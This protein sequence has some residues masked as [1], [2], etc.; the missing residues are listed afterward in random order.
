MRS[1]SH[2]D[3]DDEDG[4]SETTAHASPASASVAPDA[5]LHETVGRLMA[6]MARLERKV[7]ALRPLA[8][9]VHQLRQDIEEDRGALVTGASKTAAKHSS[10]RLAILMGALFSLYEVSAPALHEIWRQIHQ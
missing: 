5:D 2:W 4:L 10:N 1:P 8:T 7:D 6:G 9:E 3:S